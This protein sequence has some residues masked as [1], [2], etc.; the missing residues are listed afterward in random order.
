MEKD[1]VQEF[2]DSDVAV[3][4]VNNMVAY[5]LNGG[6][7]KLAFLRKSEK[8]KIILDSDLLTKQAIFGYEL[9]RLLRILKFSTSTF[10]FMC[11]TLQA[12]ANNFQEF[13]LQQG[14]NTQGATLFRQAMLALTQKSKKL[15]LKAPSPNEAAL[16]LASVF[17]HYCYAFEKF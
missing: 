12:H 9:C 10:A 15:S 7:D 1:L 3:K 16:N 4:S 14:R 13:T 6:K 8:E 17:A 5:M 11:E 2:K